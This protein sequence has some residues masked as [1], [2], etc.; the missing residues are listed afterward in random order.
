MVSAGVWAVGAVGVAVLSSVLVAVLSRRLHAAG[1][2]DAVGARSSHAQPTPRGGGLGFVA[3]ATIGWIVAAIVSPGVSAT[4]LLGVAGA[5]LAVAAVGFLDDLRGVPA[6]AR[7]LV[8]LGAAV[9][10][11]GSLSAFESIGG[12]PLIVA[13]VFATMVVGVAWLVNAFNFMD[14]TDGFAATHG[15]AA[16]GV[17]AVPLLASPAGPECTLAIVMALAVAGALLGFLPFNWP[18][19]RIFMGDV[20]SGWLGLMVALTWV[21]AGRVRPDAALAG[22]AWIAPF[23][24]DASV[25]VVRRALRGERVWQAHRSHAYQ[26]LVRRLGG[27]A[28]LLGVWWALMLGVYLPL[29]ALVA[30]TGP[31][32]WLP[33]ALAAGVAQA[34]VLK[35]GVAGVAEREAAHSAG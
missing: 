10:G 12:G 19:A 13:G 31:W 34:L 24:M 25:C 17:V 5:G 6:I 35:S 27:H 14:G 32:P 26:N 29:A 11:L 9:A 23:L 15:L 7:L 30:R 2:V 21:A 22:L 20:G 28:R 8:H 3:A 4:P 1:I 33:I 18:K 16:V